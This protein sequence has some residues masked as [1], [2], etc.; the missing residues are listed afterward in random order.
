MAAGLAQLVG[1]QSPPCSGH[2][3]DLLP[4]IGYVPAGT[5]RITFD[6]TEYMQR[7][8]A[9]HPT[10]FA[11]RPFYPSVSVDFEIQAHQTKEHFHVPL[12]WNPFGYSTYRGS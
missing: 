5:Y 3:A 12:T 6:T 10:F 1:W 2:A 9:T 7:C 4:A 8:K 11:G